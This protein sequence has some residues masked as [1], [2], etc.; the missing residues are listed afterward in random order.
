M[1]YELEITFRPKLMSQRNPH[2]H[3]ITVYK[4]GRY[5]TVSLLHCACLHHTFTP[6]SVVRTHELCSIHGCFAYSRIDG[7]QLKIIKYTGL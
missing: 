5:D 1:Y 3:K 4:Y 7:A 2:K 6:C